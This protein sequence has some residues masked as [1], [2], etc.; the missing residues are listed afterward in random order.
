EVAADELQGAAFW[1]ATAIETPWKIRRYGYHRVHHRPAAFRETRIAEIGARAVHEDRQP[2][3]IAHGKIAP[4]QRVHEAEDR[5]VGADPERQRRHRDQSEARL[6]P[7]R[8]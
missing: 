2:V 4:E 7:Q 1:P 3:G 5:R 6:L 8:A